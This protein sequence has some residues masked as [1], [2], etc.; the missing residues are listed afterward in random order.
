M[1]T[2]QPRCCAAPYLTSPR[3]AWGALQGTNR[4]RAGTA[5]LLSSPSVICSVFSDL[6][7]MLLGKS[8]AYFFFFAGAAGACLVFSVSRLPSSVPR[9]VA[10]C[11]TGGLAFLGFLS[12]AMNPLCRPRFIRIRVLT[13]HGRNTKKFRNFL[14]YILLQLRKSQKWS[15]QGS[16]QPGLIVRRAIAS[17]NLPESPHGPPPCGLSSRA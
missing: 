4:R 16:P 9:D 10:P 8:A 14:I 11:T 6:T 1:A 3:A 7:Q 15:S 2:I 13:H 5:L 12:L 17:P